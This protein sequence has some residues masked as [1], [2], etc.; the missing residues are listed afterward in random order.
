MRQ[1]YPQE[2][3]L[4]LR[5]ARPGFRARGSLVRRAFRVFCISIAG[6]TEVRL[7]LQYHHTHCSAGKRGF[8]A[9]ATAA[10]KVSSTHGSCRCP[11]LR[12]SLSYILR[13]SCS[14]S[15]STLR[16][17]SISKSRSIAGPTEI[18]SPSCLVS[19]AI[20][21]LLDRNRPVSDSSLL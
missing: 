15:C 12:P 7:R 18:R 17:P 9:W 19:V 11:L 8:R 21:D 10:E 6:P 1:V 16:I 20:T 4:L 14:A 2:F 13:G 3:F 5:P